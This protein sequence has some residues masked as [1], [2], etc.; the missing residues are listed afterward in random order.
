MHND[1]LFAGSF[2]RRAWTTLP[3][4]T[5]PLGVFCYVP[6]LQCYLGCS[7]MAGPV[8]GQHEFSQIK[9]Q[10]TYWACNKMGMVINQPFNHPANHL[11]TWAR[12]CP[13]L[14]NL[15]LPHQ[16]YH[17]P[18]EKH[19]QLTFTDETLEWY[20]ANMTWAPEKSG[21]VCTYMIYKL[22]YIWLSICMRTHS[23]KMPK[24]DTF[25]YSGSPQGRFWSK[26]KSGIWPR[27]F[28][29]RFAF[30]FPIF[31]LRA[32]IAVAGFRYT[33]PTW[34]WWAHAPGVWAQLVGLW[35]S[36]RPWQVEAWHRK[37]GLPSQPK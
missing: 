27:C 20:W 13:A 31:S 8:D 34:S 5:N 4:A 10:A 12:Q 23:Q 22:R 15:F 3:Q 36:S 30:V 14:L 16:E 1:V 25:I 11:I 7:C 21:L 19:P 17:I 24:V 37:A 35:Q 33:F 26:F 18:E 9:S 6:S 2:A 29:D 32:A 28:R